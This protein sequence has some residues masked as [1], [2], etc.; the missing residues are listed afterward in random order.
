MEC[1]SVEL[2]HHYGDKRAGLAAQLRKELH[3]LPFGLRRGETHIGIFV[4]DYNEAV[5]DRAEAVVEIGKVADG[6]GL[7]L[8][9]IQF[10]ADGEDVAAELL[11]RAS[12]RLA[13]STSGVHLHRATAAEH[14]SVLV[15]EPDRL[16]CPTLA[17]CW[18]LARLGV[19][20]YVAAYHGVGTFMGSRALAVLPACYMRIENTVL[21]LLVAGGYAKQVRKVGYAF[22]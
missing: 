17:A 5:G 8:D 18:L 13:V 12:A 1:I 2:G 11:E 22:Y 9:Y 19:E 14:S 6:V 21:D 20:P 10:E 15:A 3:H 4:D 16:C 7:A